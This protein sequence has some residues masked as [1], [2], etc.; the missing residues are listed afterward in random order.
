MFQ[1]FYNAVQLQRNLCRKENFLVKNQR[2]FSLTLY[3]KQ[4]QRDQ[5]SLPTQKYMKRWHCR[6]H[7]IIINVV[8]WLL[9]I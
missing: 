1:L 9:A 2:M 8:N 3:L 7:A 5:S 6:Y 4:P